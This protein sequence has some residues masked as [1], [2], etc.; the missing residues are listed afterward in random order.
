[1]HKDEIKTTDDIEELYNKVMNVDLRILT[2]Q[3]KVK[4]ASKKII[5]PKERMT[6]IIKEIKDFDTSYS[7]VNEEIGLFRMK[8]TKLRKLKKLLNQLEQINNSLIE[9]DKTS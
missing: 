5:F 7:N 8:V 3:L 1:M 2:E 6:E 4:L 9:H